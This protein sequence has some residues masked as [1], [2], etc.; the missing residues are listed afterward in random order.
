MRTLALQAHLIE[1]DSEGFV[2]GHDG[3]ELVEVV[4][5]PRLPRRDRA[6]QVVVAQCEYFIDEGSFDGVRQELER[7]ESVL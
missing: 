3:L 1:K 4:D 6:C 2:E 7:F 5:M